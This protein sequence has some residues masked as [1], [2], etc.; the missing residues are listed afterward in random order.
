MRKISAFA[1]ILF[2]VSVF[3]QQPI[4][5]GCQKGTQAILSGNF[6]GAATIFEPLA[7]EGDD[8]AQTSLGYLYVQGR[9]VTVD[10]VKAR[11]LWE[12]AAAKGNREAAAQAALLRH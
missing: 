3:A 2:S 4:S 10:R 1:T 8:C 11:Q 9:G 6:V 7:K 5:A 12:A